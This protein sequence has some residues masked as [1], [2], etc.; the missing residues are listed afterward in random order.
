MSGK[1]EDSQ[2]SED[3]EDLSSLGDVL[4]R[5]LGGE[6]VEGEGQVEGQYA[7]KVDDVQERHH[8]LN[9]RLVHT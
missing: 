5:V 8:K 7:Q 1:F 6:Q 9:L 2:Y 3:P 4:E